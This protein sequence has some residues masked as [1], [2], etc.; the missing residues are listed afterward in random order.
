MKLKIKCCD[1]CPCFHNDEHIICLLAGE[2]VDIDMKIFENGE[3]GRLIP[4]WCPWKKD[5]TL[6]V[7]IL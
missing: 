1:E 5:N 2:E 4:D 3:M 7:E 6:K